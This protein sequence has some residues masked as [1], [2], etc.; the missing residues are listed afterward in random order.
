MKL[1]RFVTEEDGRAIDYYGTY[2]NSTETYLI[3]PKEQEVVDIAQVA[4][5]IS[6][7]NNPNQE[8]EG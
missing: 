6:I 3:L 5:A 4:P 1:L 8:K 2:L 7:L